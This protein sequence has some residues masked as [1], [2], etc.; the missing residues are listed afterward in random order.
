MCRIRAT[1][2]GRSRFL[3]LGGL[4]ILLALLPSLGP[5]PARAQE[6]CGSWP[7]R[8]SAPC[9]LGDPGQQALTIRAAFD[10]PGQVRAFRFQVAGRGGTGVLY[11]GDLWHDV[12]VSLWREGG[13][14]GS[15]PWLRGGCDPALGCIASAR[16][17]EGRVIQFVRPKS[18]IEP[19]DPGAFVL[20]VAAP[21]V[22]DPGFARG[23]T[24]Y[25]SVQPRAC[26]IRADETGRYML[27][28]AVQP[29]QPSR[30]DLLTFSAFVAPPFGDLFEFEWQVDGQRVAGPAR[31]IVQRAASDLSGGPSGEHTVRVA[32]RGVRPYPDP[33]QPEIP[34]TIDLTCSFRVP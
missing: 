21:P 22:A 25:V 26:G 19:L 5:T 16:P 24:T 1:A 20:A 7:A 15:A 2:G 17:S 9:E 18:L 31:E 23:F 27:G 11:V 6:P 28:L 14:A 29:G 30:F 8:E 34:P 33:A 10:A 13:A 32:A 4:I 3:L 12:D